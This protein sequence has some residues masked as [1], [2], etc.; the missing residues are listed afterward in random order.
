MVERRNVV[1]GGLAAGLAALVTGAEA[2]VAAAPQ[3]DDNSREVSL[4]L[5]ELRQMIESN[6]SRPWTIIARIREQQR[7]W[8]RANHKYPD[9]IEVGADVWD[10]LYDWHVRF[11]QP[12]SMTRSADGRYVMSFMFTTFILRPEQGVDYVGPGFDGDRRPA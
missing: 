10:A 8:L 11:Q 5:R 12:I 2:D 7:I 9:F 6:F 1:G 3:R 4:E